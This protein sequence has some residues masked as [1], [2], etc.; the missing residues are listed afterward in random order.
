MIV[1]VLAECET[2]DFNFLLGTTGLTRGNLSA[3]MARLVS[4]G[5]VCES[6]TFLDRKP[7]TEYRLSPAGRKAFNQY[8]KSWRRLTG[9]SS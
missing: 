6:K 9:K 1:S 3:H 4:A 5:Y 8:L 7:H 2:A